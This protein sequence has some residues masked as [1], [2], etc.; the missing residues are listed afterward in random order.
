MALLL[1]MWHRL[2]IPDSSALPLSPRPCA[3]EQHHGI[4]GSRAGTREASVA[5][6]GPLTPT[7]GRPQY[8]TVLATPYAPASGSAGPVY[9]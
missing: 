9:N 7:K 8:L 3:Q 6:V 1:S 5:M 4:R 2:C